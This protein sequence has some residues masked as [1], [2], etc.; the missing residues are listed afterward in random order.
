LQI[1]FQQYSYIAGDGMLHPYRP[2][3]VVEDAVVAVLVVV[4]QVDKDAAVDVDAE[5]DLVLIL[6]HVCAM[7]WIFQT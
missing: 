3:A 5:V 6:G 7:G 4:V 1:F 2:V